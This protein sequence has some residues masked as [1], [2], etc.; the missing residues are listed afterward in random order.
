M[1]QAL[2]DFLSAQ[3]VQAPVKLYSDWLFVGHVD[4]F[5]SF[6]PVHKV[7]CGGL[8][9]G[10]HTPPPWAP[11]FCSALCLGRGGGGGGGPGLTCRTSFPSTPGGG[12][13]GSKPALL[14]A[15]GAKL[16]SD[17]S[18]SCLQGFRLLLA[19]PRSCYRLFQEQLKEGHG[20]ALLFEGVKS[21]LAGPCVS[22]RGPFS[23][24][25]WPPVARWG[26]LEHLS[27]EH[28]L[29]SRPCAP[30]QGCCVN[31]A[32]ELPAAAATARSPGEASQENSRSTGAG[33][34]VGGVRGRLPGGGKDQA[35][36]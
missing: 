13:P 26:H 30:G 6:V 24:L 22:T 25:A 10:R 36:A 27:S 3:Q 9:G 35:G 17:P 20:E 19:S 11:R 31:R 12:Q 32:D 1:H 8:P 29:C 2:Q 5:L 7:Q 18:V 21:K 4:E 15:P 16:T 34:Y 28:P 33:G 14:G 23:A